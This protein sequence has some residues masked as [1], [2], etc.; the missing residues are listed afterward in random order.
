M[1]SPAPEGQPIKQLKELEVNACLKVN[2]EDEVTTLEIRFSS[3]QLKP[4]EAPSNEVRKLAIKLAIRAL[5]KA[6][7]QIN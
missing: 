7:A 1:V 2:A 6:H 3:P 5:E 4:G